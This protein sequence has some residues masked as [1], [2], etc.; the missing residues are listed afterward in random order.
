MAVIDDLV[1]ALQASANYRHVSPDLIRHVGEEELGKRRNLKAA[2]KSTKDKLHQVGG[3]FLAAEMPYARWL[4]DVQ[5]ATTPAELRATCR[6]IMAHHAS[7][8]ERLPFLEDFYAAIFADLPPIASVLDLAC[9]LHPLALP[10]MPLPA[11]ASYHAYDIYQP[12]MDFI[13]AF[14]PLAGMR[15]EATT[16]DISQSLPTTPVDLALLLKAIPTLE[17]IDKTAGQRILNE[18]QARYLVVSFPCRSLGGKNKGMA[19]FY[20]AHFRALV[21]D[22]PWSIKRV[23]FPTE[24]VFVVHKEPLA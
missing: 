1:A 13:S 24:L 21:A 16:W 15:G 4:A 11:E 22:K 23:L 18:I 8:R 17:Q 2:I 19:D 6:A 9:G 7:M 12:M 20:E 10:W 3:A 14:L 5:A